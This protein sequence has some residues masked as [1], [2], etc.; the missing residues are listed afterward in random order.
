MPLPTP[1]TILNHTKFHHWYPG[2]EAALVSILNWL[3]NPSKRFL[4]ASMPTGSGKSVLAALAQVLGGRR[5]AVLTTTKGLQNQ[6]IQ[7]FEEKPG[8]VDIRGQG[9]YLCSLVED[10]E[11]SVE[12]G[13]CHAGIYCSLKTSG[14]SYYDKLR[15]AKQSNMLITNYSYYLAQ[16]HYGDGMSNKLDISG[17]KVD[18]PI[19]LLVCDEAHLAFQA[20]ESFMAV[21]FS[22]SEIQAL[23]VHFPTVDTW[24]TWQ[25]WALKTAMK[26]ELEHENIKGEIKI[27]SE[28]GGKVT[29][30]MLRRAKH[31]GN[32]VIR[33]KSLSAANGKW[34]WDKKKSGISFTPVWPGQH[35]NLLYQLTPKIL[36]MSATL[37]PKTADSLNIPEAQ[38]EWLEVPSYF[39]KENS[40]IVHVKTA[41]MN[42]KI[43]P[44]DLNLWVTRIDQII[45][46]RKD[47]K[48]IVFTVSY[49]RRNYLMSNSHHVKIMYTHDKDNIYA[50]VERFKNAPPPAVLVSP[51]VTSGWDFAGDTCSYGIVSKIPYPD[52]RDTVVKAR[53]EEDN[54][55]GAYLAMQTLVQECGRGT[56]SAEDKCEYLICD[57]SWFWFW[58][59]YKHFSPKWFQDRVK[60][61]VVEIVPEPM[62]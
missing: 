49:E 50:I 2:Q 3:N 37:S 1:N 8:M 55:W 29:G 32:L 59:R 4:C 16:T 33:L 53:C 9:N 21:Y 27:L 15:V 41:R 42:Y 7:D 22:N 44:E 43:T 17:C 23:G 6:Y 12:D 51:T 25:D 52:T 54:D 35:A 26:A 47:R 38:R 60:S 31:Y 5:T 34:I 40:P 58:K 20:I 28:E 45:N 46:K 36:L 39:P 56:R 10:G 19:Q 62:V 13:S 11:T 14:C 24:E 30:A 61:G 57:D 18:K 48:G